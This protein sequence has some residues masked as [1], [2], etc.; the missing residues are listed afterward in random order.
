M[1]GRVLFVELGINATD[2]DILDQ[3]RIMKRAREERSY[4]NVVCAIRGYDDDHR[5][6]YDIPEV[7][8]FCRRLLS[9]GFIS[10]LDFSTRPGSQTPPIAR[11]CWGAT[12]VW[13]C[14]KGRMKARNVVT[15]KTMS[16]FDD[17]LA[18]SN[19][20]ADAALGPTIPCARASDLGVL[21]KQRTGELRGRPKTGMFGNFDPAMF[22][23]PEFK[24]D[25]VREEIVVPILKRLGYS[26]SGPN[27]IVRGKALKHPFVMIGS[28]RHQVNIVPD[29]LLYTEGR[30]ACVVDAKR[31][32]AALVKSKHAEQ[33]Y[34]Y[35]IHPD[36]R[37]RF[38]AL[39][40]GRQLVAYDTSGIGPIFVIEF[41]EIERDWEIVESVLSPKN[42]GLAAQRHFAP[43]LGTAL[44]KMGYAPGVQWLFPLA[45]LSQFARVS[46]ELFTAATTIAIEGV[47]HLAS[48]DAERE[49]FK[50]LLSLTDEENR[51]C[52]LRS[53]AI[54]QL[55]FSRRP[56]YV[57]LDTTLGEPTQGQHDV[58]VP[59]VISNV[60]P[61][62][63][64]TYKSAEAMLGNRQTE[65]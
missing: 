42:V 49:M 14:G 36:V 16:A 12:E 39:C 5:E 18:E 29:Y 6:L 51:N 10:Y 4:D 64:Q 50:K 35:A 7:R 33:A 43:N 44:T 57:T 60:A 15:V 1:A 20:K 34:S 52:L 30:P 48:F 61:L 56:I 59:F 40:N 8:S 58:F 2:G 45:K 27:K 9:F 53:L 28:K 21:P 63:E 65:A 41:A 37:V 22:H 26:A 24:E 47:D 25:S 13:Q 23:D 62:D 31:P 17:A 46:E 19:R 11:R 54:G 38:Y 3:M 55:V 32:D